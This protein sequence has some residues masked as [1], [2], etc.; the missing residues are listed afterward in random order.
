MKRIGILSDTHGMWDDR[1]A[2]HFKDCDEIWHAGDIGDYAIIERLRETAPVRAVSGNIDHGMVRRKCPETDI[3]TIEGVRVLL[4]HI[5]G[6]PG[7]W[8]PGMKRL[9][10]EERIKLMVDGHS[11]LLKIIFDNELDLLHINPGAAGNQGWQRVRTL[12]RITIDGTEM[13]DCEII[14]LSN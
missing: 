9:L 11:H 6:Y 3:F 7:K 5:G 4:T 14:E 13:R 10:K 1:Y 2:L 12:V 8:S